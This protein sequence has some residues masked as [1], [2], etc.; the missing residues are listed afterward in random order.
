MHFGF[1]EILSGLSLTRLNSGLTSS[2]RRCH[3]VQLSTNCGD[4]WV[5]YSIYYGIRP[6]HLGTILIE[7]TSVEGRIFWMGPHCHPMYSEA[8]EY[9]CLRHQLSQFRSHI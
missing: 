1:V 9:Y 7:I 4:D 6:L 8:L 2:H 5:L 3:H